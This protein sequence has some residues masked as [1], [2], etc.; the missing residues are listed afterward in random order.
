MPGSS[1]TIVPNQEAA[2]RAPRNPRGARPS[3]RFHTAAG[4]RLARE[5]IREMLWRGFEWPG[6]CHEIRMAVQAALGEHVHYEHVEMM[7]LS[8]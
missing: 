4:R 2:R 1:M 6:D 5:T 3:R 7:V 8:V